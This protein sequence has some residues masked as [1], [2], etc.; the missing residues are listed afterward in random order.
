MTRLGSVYATDRFEVHFPLSADEYR[1][2]AV[3]HLDAGDSVPVVVR[4]TDGSGQEWA[5]KLL[6]ATGIFDPQTH[7]TNVVVEI[8]QAAVADEPAPRPGQ[9]VR[10]SLPGR[11]LTEA[12][13]LPRAALQPDGG[14]F[15]V[16]A[17][18]RLLHRVVEIVAKSADFIVIGEGLADGERVSLTP[19][20]T[21]IDGMPVEPVPATLQP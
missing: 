12:V 8:P 16:D 2:L 15:V 21:F 13:R 20:L 9:F 4:A 18:N 10:A 5:G 3:E 14:V 17:D 19:M 7:L 6:R 11:V 1:R